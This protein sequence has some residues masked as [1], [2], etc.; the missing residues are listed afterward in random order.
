M[1]F[2]QLDML[3]LSKRKSPKLAANLALFLSLQSEDS[4]Y[5]VYSITEILATY[6][7]SWPEA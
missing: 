1:T 2:P 3:S 6:R 5:L 7:T 4:V